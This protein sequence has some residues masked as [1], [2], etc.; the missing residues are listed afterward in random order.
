MFFAIRPSSAGTLKMIPG[1]PTL[2]LQGFGHTVASEH[3]AGGIYAH[4]VGTGDPL[5]LPRCVFALWGSQHDSGDM[6]IRISGDGVGVLALSGAGDTGPLRVKAACSPATTETTSGGEDL[7]SGWVK[8][9][10]R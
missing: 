7:S 2:I 5:A 3:L 8:R 1:E 4:L 6:K 9:Q 10:G